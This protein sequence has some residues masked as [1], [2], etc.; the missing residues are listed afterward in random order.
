MEVY[1]QMFFRASVLIFVV[2]L[3]ATA[4]SIALPLSQNDQ[5]TVDLRFNLRMTLGVPIGEFQKQFP[6]GKCEGNYAASSCTLSPLPKE[7][8]T[9]VNCLDGRVLFS[10]SKACGLLANAD[11][12]E[13]YYVKQMMEKLNPAPEV[14]RKSSTET[15]YITRW[16]GRDGNVFF[17]QAVSNTR[18][19]APTYTIGFIGLPPYACRG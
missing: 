12:G 15:L 19:H 17:T 2:W 9:M 16:R 7:F 3:S 5:K 14:V 8:C 13:W 6:L 11:L 4:T 10:K 18:A 1:Q